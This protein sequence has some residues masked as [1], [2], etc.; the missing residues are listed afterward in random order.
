MDNLYAIAV[1]NCLC[2]QERNGLPLQNKNVV[3]NVFLKHLLTESC[4]ISDLFVT[5]GIL[6][7]SSQMNCLVFSLLSF[8]VGFKGPQDPL[9]PSGWQPE[10]GLTYA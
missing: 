3:S 1:P 5:H 4:L 9:F 2:F 8:S 7:K 6:L 10:P